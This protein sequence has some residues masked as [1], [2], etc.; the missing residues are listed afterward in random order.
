MAR[1]RIEYPLDKG[2]GKVVNRKIFVNARDEYGVLDKALKD[3]EKF[4]QTS[5]GAY[6]MKK[7]RSKPK[8]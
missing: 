6:A 1:W 7:M 3:A 5:L 8:K 4:G 2:D